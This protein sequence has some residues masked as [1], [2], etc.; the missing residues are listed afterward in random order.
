MGKITVN[1][2]EFETVGKP[3][4]IPYN[5]VTKELLDAYSKGM[6][7][8]WLI[9]EMEICRSYCSVILSTRQNSGFNSVKY[10][11]FSVKINRYFLP[12]FH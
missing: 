11:L 1:G 6:K 2:V 9:K 5:S 10:P 8:K 4:V 7:E 12:E 3:K